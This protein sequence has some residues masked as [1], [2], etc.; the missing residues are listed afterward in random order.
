MTEPKTTHKKTTA[1]TAENTQPDLEDDNETASEAEV[2]QETE[3]SELSDKP[4][5][6]ESPRTVSEENAERIEE[7]KGEEAEEVKEG[8][9][10]EDA[11]AASEE[12]VPTK[13]PAEELEILAELWKFSCRVSL[14]PDVIRHVAPF[15]KFRKMPARGQRIL[16]D[17]LETD[18]EFRKAVL[19]EWQKDPLKLESEHLP[20]MIEMWLA[21]PLR[22]RDEVDR[23]I[24]LQSNLQTV[25]S[26]NADLQAKLRQAEAEQQRARNLQ[27][28][29]QKKT[30][31]AKSQ[32]E[33]DQMKR[34]QA[35]SQA[36]KLA[37][38]YEAAKETVR[39]LKAELAS[40]SDGLQSLQRHHNKLRKTLSKREQRINQLEREVRHLKNPEA[41]EVPDERRRG[42]TKD[43]I[44]GDALAPQEP[45]LPIPPPPGVSQFS[46]TAAEHYVTETSVLFVD[47]YNFIY[48]A[49]P[50]E[51]EHLQ[52]G[53]TE[54]FRDNNKKNSG[55][56]P[57]LEVFRNRLID[58]ALSLEARFRPYN[59]DQICLVFDGKYPAPQAEYPPQ[60]GIHVV[61]SP[62]DKIAD[63]EIVERLSQYP[64]SK[65]IAVVSD[66]QELRSRCYD[67]GATIM[68]VTQLL[69]LFE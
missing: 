1:K 59:L 9:S 3:D 67:K 44:W 7:N 10:S 15:A 19:E 18:S 27:A 64:N 52:P 55:H 16:R 6:H 38:D 42:F 50:D 4:L 58:K 62:P 61:F 25:S 35:E 2:P 48:I 23:F 39:R 34:A 68:S 37:E 17:A 40:E 28:K 32:S 13:Y 12:S 11:D 65:Q 56:K 41:E 43:E 45:R 57:G 20:A 60:S 66:D 47:G 49:W 24:F 14:P 5:S 63:D 46:R 31:K 8:E 54:R 53:K 51:T 36:E 29:R 22:W 33:K 69:Y 26:E 30:A 21:R